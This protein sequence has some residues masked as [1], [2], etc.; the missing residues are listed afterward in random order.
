MQHPEDT[1]QAIRMILLVV[2]A[3]VGLVGMATDT[4]WLVYGALVVLAVGLAIA[5][6]RRV[7]LRKAGHG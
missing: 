1:S 7:R 6:I 2:G 3:G 4:S 5:L